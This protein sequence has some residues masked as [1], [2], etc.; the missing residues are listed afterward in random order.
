MLAKIHA[1][2]NKQD[3]WEP[4]AGGGEHA[5]KRKP[6]GKRDAMKSVPGGRPEASRLR[7][8]T[9]TVRSLRQD[10]RGGYL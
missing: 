8:R 4:S 1:F 5:R 6:D 2:L 10:S 3:D 9:R 7:A